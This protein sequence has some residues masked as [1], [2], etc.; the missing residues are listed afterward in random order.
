VYHDATGQGNP[1]E[2]PSIFSEKVHIFAV[3]LQS[4]IYD[5]GICYHFSKMILQSDIY[6]IG[7]CY[8]FSKMILQSA[9]IIF[10][11]QKSDIAIYY[12]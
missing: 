12:H 2:T 6:D 4:D 7:I 10:V 1:P 9:I 8:H 3:I 11:F 5:I